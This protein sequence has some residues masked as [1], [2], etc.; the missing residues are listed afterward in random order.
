MALTLKEL[1]KEQHTSVEGSEFA[2]VLLSGRINPALY[3]E[4]L[5]AQYECYKVLE[6][7][8]EIP[9]KIKSIFRAGLIMEDMHELEDKYE[10]EEITVRPYAVRSYIK[11]ITALKEAGDNDKLLAHL[12]VRHFG[13][14]H[15]GQIIKKRIPGSGFMYEFA[16]RKQLIEDTRALLDD[17]MAEEA[18]VCFEFA[19]HLFEELIENFDEDYESDDL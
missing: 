11:H 18:K 13:D 10:F 8:V 7:S 6:E 17:S 12:Y 9:K 16:G 15:G 3:Y 19:E 14:L 5:S 1:T 4:Y 2:D